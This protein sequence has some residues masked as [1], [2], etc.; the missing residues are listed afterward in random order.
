MEKNITLYD[1]YCIMGCDDKLQIEVVN[2]TTG[3]TLIEKDKRFFI[4][5]LEKQPE[6]YTVILFDINNKVIRVKG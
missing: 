3:K 4:F 1:L 2:E 5:N 6:S